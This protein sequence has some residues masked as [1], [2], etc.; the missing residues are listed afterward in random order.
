MLLK[1]NAGPLDVWITF[2]PVSKLWSFISIELGIFPVV[3]VVNPA[4]TIPAATK[5]KGLN[6]AFRLSLLYLTVTVVEI[7]DFAFIKTVS[8]VESP[9]V[10]D[11]TTVTRFFSSSP[12]TTSGNLVLKLWFDPIPAFKK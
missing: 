5:F 2:W 10:P 4:V 12:L 6:T 11:P 7:P 1:P 9:C 3:V 8:F